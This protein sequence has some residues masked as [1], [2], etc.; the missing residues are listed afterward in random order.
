MAVF[1]KTS[2]TNR[3][4]KCGTRA[5]E[6]FP[7]SVPVPVSIVSMA[8]DVV[9]VLMVLILCSSDDFRGRVISVRLN[10]KENHEFLFTV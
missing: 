6:T 9:I 10:R 1:Y 3:P 8:A 4:T 5:Y 2:C 7:K